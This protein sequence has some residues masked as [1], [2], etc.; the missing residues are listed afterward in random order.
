VL[1]PGVLAQHQLAAGEALVLRAR[2]AE[3][4]EEEEDDEARQRCDVH[5][6]VLP[7]ERGAPEARPVG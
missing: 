7:C 6:T 3:H 5:V 1:G 2:D 4:G